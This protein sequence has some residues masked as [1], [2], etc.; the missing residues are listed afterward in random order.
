MSIVHKTVINLYIEYKI[1]TYFPQL[2]K[3]PSGRNIV[4]ESPLLFFVYLFQRNVGEDGDKE[5]LGN[6]YLPNSII[7]KDSMHMEVCQ[8]YK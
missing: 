4:L 2:E 5:A 1:G 3:L 7:G 8:V 6:N